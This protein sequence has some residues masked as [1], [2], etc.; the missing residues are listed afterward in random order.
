[1][2]A[3]GGFFGLWWLLEAQRNEL[4]VVLISTLMI[5]KRKIGYVTLNPVEWKLGLKVLFLGLS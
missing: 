5:L 1:M 4:T 3:A 2:F